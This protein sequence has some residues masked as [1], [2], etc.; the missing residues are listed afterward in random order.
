[1]ER[2]ILLVDD[3]Q[4]ILAALTRLLRRD[5][6]Q[7]L[8]ANSGAAGLEMLKDNA[9][10][11]I[12]SDQRMPEMTGVEFLGRVKQLYPDTVR[13]VLSGYTDL[14]SITDSINEGA[15]YKFLTKPWDDELLRSNVR[16]AFAR[17]EL[18]QENY[19][20]S[21]QLLTANSELEKV[22]AT[23]AQR[24]KQKTHD[25]MLSMT[26]LQISQDIL[27]YLPLAVVGVAKDGMVVVVNQL[28]QQWLAAAPLIGQPI[29][30]VVPA[31]IVDVYQQAINHGTGHSQQPVTLPSL[32]RCHVQCV[33]LGNAAKPRGWIIVMIAPQ[34]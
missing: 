21:Q 4:N 27:E 11:V 7:I 16:E 23:L 26:A 3:E 33:P 24:V 15:I 2:I 34:G 25:A 18:K 12:I 31:E 9:V 8:S 19:M 20:L 32:D 5:G 10:G 6:Y 22:N 30:R 13:I 29:H 17:Y 28:A 14:K 1:M